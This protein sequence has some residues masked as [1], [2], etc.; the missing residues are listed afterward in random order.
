M[1]PTGNLRSPADGRSVRREGFAPGRF[2]PSPFQQSQ[3]QVWPEHP[4]RILLHRPEAGQELLRPYHCQLLRLRK[5]HRQ[6]PSP[7]LG[8][9]AG[10]GLLGKRP[11]SESIA[12]DAPPLRPLQSLGCEKGRARGWEWEQGADTDC[13]KA[14]LGID[15]R[16]HSYPPSP[17]RL[18]LHQGCT[19][20]ARH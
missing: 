15:G 18:A 13:L 19:E 2:S 8:Q 6:H 7:S 10:V 16:P 14:Q 1:G 3:R 17:V 9:H 20:D 11:S 4:R 5:S 12:V